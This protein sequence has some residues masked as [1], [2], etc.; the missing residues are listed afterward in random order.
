MDSYKLAGLNLT[1]L[2]MEDCEIENFT[3]IFLQ[4][5]LFKTRILTFNVDIC[6]RHIQDETYDYF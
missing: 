4:E 2:T 1:S 3:W 6:G 5:V